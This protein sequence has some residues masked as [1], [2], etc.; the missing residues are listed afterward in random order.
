MNKLNCSDCRHNEN[1]ALPFNPCRICMAKKRFEPIPQ[2]EP[3]H[4]GIDFAKGK[5]ETVYFPIGGV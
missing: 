5:D 3:I 4:I 2:E 1:K